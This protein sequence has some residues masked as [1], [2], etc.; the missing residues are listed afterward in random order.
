M[1]KKFKYRVKLAIPFSCFLEDDDRRKFGFPILEDRHI[2]I[3]SEVKA[4]FESGLV[5]TSKAV[6]FLLVE[7][8]DL[9]ALVER[10]HV[11]A[12]NIIS[13][14]LEGYG[15]QDLTVFIEIEEIKVVLS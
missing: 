15:F 5:G 6:I 11:T 4:A 10:R 14:E 7:P 12:K 13:V 2:T 1:A 8:E 9:N 3:D